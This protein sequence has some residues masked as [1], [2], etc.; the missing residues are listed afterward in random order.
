MKVYKVPIEKIN[1]TNTKYI[2]SYPLMP[3]RM[4]E[5]VKNAGILQPILVE[6][7]KDEY[8]VLDGIR[9]VLAAKKLGI[10]NIYIQ[11]YEGPD[12]I[13]DKIKTVIYAN[14]SHRA[15][16][17]VE[18]AV[19]MSKTAGN[20]GLLQIVLNILGISQNIILIDKY[21]RL[22]NEENSIKMLVYEGRL[23]LNSVYDLTFFNYADKSQIVL[24][25]QELQ[26]SA[27][28]AQEIIEN[29]KDII[30]GSDNEENT[31]E[32]LAHAVGVNEIFGN[33]SLNVSEKLGVLRDR[34][35][36][37]RYPGLSR[38]EEEF[39]KFSKSLNCINGVSCGHTPFF[40]NES[41]E[42]K[43]SY[44]NYHELNQKIEQ[45]RK[46]IENEEY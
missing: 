30:L 35:R 46:K 26:C 13:F 40:E 37:K 10:E 27:S 16:N 1:T 25:T 29:S 45:V 21:K 28:I 22:A 9:R 12:S 15:F 24:L 34:I 19:I 5:S 38:K 41:K 20:S 14:M 23:K 39:N 11:E 31:F 4:V 42:L 8:F 36:K 6:K 17:E 3:D 32:E 33:D 18:K 44:N 7:Q 43:I 2:F